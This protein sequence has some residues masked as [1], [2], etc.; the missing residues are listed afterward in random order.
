MV[1]A[2]GQINDMSYEAAFKCIAGAWNGKKVLR[3]LA[4]H[5]HHIVI[6]Q[7][8]LDLGA[9]KGRMEV[10]REAGKEAG[11][12]Y[13]FI[14]IWFDIPEFQC[15]QNIEKRGDK[16]A[17]R[18]VY[19]KLKMTFYPPGAAEFDLFHRLEDTEDWTP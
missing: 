7:T 15:L 2:F 5:G 8:N 19:F 9:R 17:G 6:D 4:R 10:I 13:K 12:D 14:G 11:Y 16:G 3:G 1:T 18:D